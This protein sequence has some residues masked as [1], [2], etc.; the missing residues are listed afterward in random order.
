MRH[1]VP[2]LAVLLLAAC[3]GP[4]GPQGSMGATGA[5]GSP[6]AMGATGSTGATGSPGAQGPAGPILSERA[7][8]GL[9]LSPVPIDTSKLTAAEA[10]QVGTGAYLAN[11]AFCT[12]CHTSNPTQFMA[13]GVPFFL[14]GM[15]HVVWTRNLTPDK[16]TGL[17]RF[18]LDQFRT[19]MK[20]GLDFSSPD[21]GE[22]LEVDSWPTFRWLS[23]EDLTAIWAYLQQ[24]PPVMNV[25]PPDDKGPFRHAPVPFPGRWVDGDVPRELPPDG[26]IDPDNVLRGL[27]IQPLATPSTFE[28]LDARDQALFG[29]GSYIVNAL[30]DCSGC[31]TNPSRNFADGPD[32]LRI[33]TARYLEGGA[34]WVVPPFRQAQTGYVR[35]MSP[36][37]IGAGEG[38][39]HETGISFPLFDSLLATGLHVDDPDPA[40]LAWPMQWAHFRLMTLDDLEAVYTY[41][42]TLD[43][44]QVDR[45]N[46]ES[47]R[48]CLM[49]SECRAGETCFGVNADAG[50][51]GE[52]LASTC[53]VDADCDACQ[54]CAT[55]GSGKQ[56]VA[57]APGSLCVFNGGPGV[58][59][60]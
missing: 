42:R 41:M 36:N 21:G 44:P 8:T 53:S 13:G 40:R 19:I 52:C 26:G 32:F 38:F 39:F 11:I 6:G 49:D 43:S 10:E 48:F 35:S 16:T 33:N 28:T 30:A 25:T 50:V 17:G 3:E 7:L 55:V 51:G 46:Q 12:E 54:T 45:V 27:A 59:V 18:T 14:D 23:D 9:R 5:T 20:T 57:P 2:L 15:G 56:C 58:Q 34:V 4:A 29:R 1:I 24:I 37:L 22:A 60:Q 31:H 47:A